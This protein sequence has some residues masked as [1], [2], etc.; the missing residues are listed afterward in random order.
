MRRLKTP[1]TGATGRGNPGKVMLTHHQ[2]RTELLL[3]AWGV[4]A[5]SLRCG[6]IRERQLGGRLCLLNT[7]GGRKKVEST[8]LMTLPTSLC[9]LIYPQRDKIS[10]AGWVTALGLAQ[11]RN[12]ASGLD[13]THETDFSRWLHQP[14]GTSCSPRSVESQRGKKHSHTHTKSILVR[15]YSVV[16]QQKAVDADNAGASV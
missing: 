7:C 10:V 4:G 2:R 11:G 16:K 12:N 9:T 8:A 1:D 14:V 5:G 6:V 13:K 3:T 15:R